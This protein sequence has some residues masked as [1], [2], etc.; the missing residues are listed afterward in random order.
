MLKWQMFEV[1]DCIVRNEELLELAKKQVDSIFHFC[2]LREQKNA[3]KR[4]Y[5]IYNKV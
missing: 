2:H 5:N 4:V 3:E 1:A